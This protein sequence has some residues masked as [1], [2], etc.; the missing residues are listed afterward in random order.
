M[1]GFFIANKAQV[2][3]FFEYLPYLYILLVPAL[4]MRLWSEERKQG[5]MEVLMTLPLRE[6]EVLLGKFLAAWSILLITLVLTLPIPL[7]VE[8]MG[9][10]D[11]GP[12]LGGYFA[13]AMLGAAYI[14]VGIFMSGLSRNQILS[15]IGSAVI[16]AAFVAMGHGTFLRLLED[17]WRPLYHMGA[18]LGF[19]PHF[20]SVRRGVLDT[21]D[22]VY[23]LSF[24]F[25]FLVLNRFSIEVHRYS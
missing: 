11:W 6:W 16:L 1:G 23:F 22:I 24:S 2:R 14:S 4:T 18:G 9:D 5:T 13:S 7:F 10:L 15:F 21:K 19:L 25:L 8:F 20:E 3:S 12:V 17:T